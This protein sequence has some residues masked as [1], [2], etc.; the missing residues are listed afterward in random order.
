MDLMEV[1]CEDARWIEL[2][3][4]CVQWGAGFAVS[5]I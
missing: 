3:Q 2:V 4:D 5:G 1:R